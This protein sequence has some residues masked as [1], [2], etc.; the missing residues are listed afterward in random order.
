M[1]HRRPTTL[2]RLPV[3]VVAVLA[4]LAFLAPAASAATTPTWSLVD[5]HDSRCA[6][7]GG[8]GSPGSYAVQIKG[9]WTRPIAVGLDN[10]PA[11]V[12]A[13]PLQSPI[14]PGSSDGTKELAYVSVG[15][16]RRQ[17]TLGTYTLSLWA[18]DGVV[19][20]RVPV[21][22]ILQSTRCSAY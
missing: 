1:N 21:T 18:D 16:N 15:V 10:L 13:T 5:L 22:L 14:P 17:A 2:G 4:S 19:R 3:F 20:Q 6:H 8:G 12:T 11:G 7:V 9:R